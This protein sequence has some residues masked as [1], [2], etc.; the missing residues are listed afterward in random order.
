MAKIRLLISLLAFIFC[1]S[2]LAQS[3]SEVWTRL[4]FFSESLIPNTKVT[5]EGQYRIQYQTRF[6]S[7][8]L[9]TVTF[10]IW[11]LGKLGNTGF[12]YQSSPI[13]IFHRKSVNGAKDFESTEIRLTQLAGYK[14]KSMPLEFRTGLEWRNFH[15][16]NSLI[17]EWRWRI[18]AQAVLRQKKE[19]QPIL[20]TEY[21]YRLS[22]GENQMDQLRLTGGIRGNFDK[23]EAELGYQHHFRNPKIN[24]VTSQVIYLNL[25]PKI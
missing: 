9:N 20:A 25:T 22:S 4:S 3:R 11:I 10:R 24:R 15:Q 16:E 17:Q 6:T 19:I 8:D 13:A 12:Y 23:I 2:L 14:L 7:S 5:F 18:R 21:F 1:N